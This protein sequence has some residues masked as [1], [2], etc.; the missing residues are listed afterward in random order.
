MQILVITCLGF[1]WEID[2]TAIVQHKARWIQS[3]DTTRELGAISAEITA[4][5]LQDPYLLFDWYQGNM[6]WKDVPCHA[7]R[8]TQTPYLGTPEALTRVLRHGS[9]DINYTVEERP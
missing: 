7:K 3:R 4:E 9:H 5:C 2:G 1:Q 8:C 6:D